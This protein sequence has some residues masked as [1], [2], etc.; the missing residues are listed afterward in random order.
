MTDLI[1][2][3]DLDRNQLKE[4]F[5][6]IGE[7]AFRADQV[8]KGMYQNLAQSPEEITALPKPLRQKLSE[9]IIFTHLKTEDRLVSSDAETEKHSS[10]YRMEPGSKPS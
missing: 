6:A 2:F 9:E 3:F 7:P 8:W 10:H 5:L 1:Y 4:Y